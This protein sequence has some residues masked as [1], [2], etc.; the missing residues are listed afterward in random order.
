MSASVVEPETVAVR[1]AESVVDRVVEGQANVVIEPTGLDVDR[2]VE[3]IPV[4]ALATGH[5][6]STSSRRPCTSRSRC[7]ATS[8]SRPCR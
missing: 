6:R 2:E 3:L 1:G 8:E 7:S 5:A 4:D